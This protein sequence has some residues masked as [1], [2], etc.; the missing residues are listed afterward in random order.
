MSLSSFLGLSRQFVELH[1]QKTKEPLY[2]HIKRIRKVASGRGTASMLHTIVSGT[3]CV[4]NQLTQTDRP[5][6]GWKWSVPQHTQT[7]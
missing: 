1:H 3:A 5:S 6:G 7:L 2:L 4:V